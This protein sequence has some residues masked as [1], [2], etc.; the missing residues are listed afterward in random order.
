MV[1][2]IFYAVFFYC[3]FSAVICRRV[4]F[5]FSIAIGKRHRRDLC[6]LFF[7]RNDGEYSN[8]SL[9]IFI[10]S[11]RISFFVASSNSFSW[12]TVE[13][14]TERG[15]HLGSGSGINSIIICTEILSAIRMH[16]NASRHWLVCDGG[17][18]SP[19]SRRA[20]SL[21]LARIL[22]WNRHAY[23]RRCSSICV[24]MD[25]NQH[26]RDSSCRFRCD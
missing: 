2:I 18:R 7:C 1:P 6:V 13:F 16:L 20:T 19:Y 4:S 23:A 24:A 12:C 15:A 17:N 26:I 9:Q 22:M 11:L 8:S 3:W 10:Y 5:V 14:S 21:S 25:A